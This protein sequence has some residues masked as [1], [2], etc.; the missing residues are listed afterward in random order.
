MKINQVTTHYRQRLPHI[1]LVGAT[2][3]VTFRLQDSIPRVRLFKLKK[4]FEQEIATINKENSPFKKDL[5]YAERKRFFGR[6]DA[7]LD[8]IN[9]GPLYLKQPEIAQLVINELHR[10]N[11]DLYDLIAYCVMANHV[12]ILI[13]T[14]TD[15]TIVL[16]L[17]FI[18]HYN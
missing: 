9:K 5:I 18:E 7:L 11:G 10:F 16:N 3:F 12:H 4:A 14:G 1:Q 15:I 6:Y 17:A 2:F 8:K 13:D